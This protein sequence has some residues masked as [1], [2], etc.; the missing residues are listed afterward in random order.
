VPYLLFKFLGEFPK[1]MKPGK[2]DWLFSSSAAVFLL[3]LAF[4]FEMVFLKSQRP[5]IQA[6]LVFV[7]LFGA[8]PLV[9]FRDK[10]GKYFFAGSMI[11]LL[12]PAVLY[13]VISASVKIGLG[14]LNMPHNPR[15]NGTEYM[16]YMEPMPTGEKFDKYDYDAINWINQNIKTIEP[17]VEAA[18][19]EMYRGYSRI[20]IFTGL[21][22]LIGWRYQE[23]QQSGRDKESNDAILAVEKIYGSNDP[24]E[25]R[26]VAKAMNVN[27]VYVG[28]LEKWKY[29]EGVKKFAKIATVVYANAGAELYK[30]NY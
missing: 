17:I 12:V 21:P 30:I 25:A 19:L 11:F 14:S 28:S 8:L 22:T 24:E 1:V 7:V 5:L 10:I 15:I 20:S 29:P 26:A 16:K 23:V 9:L 13:P 27:Y 18:G 4:V 3:V 2:L 6:L